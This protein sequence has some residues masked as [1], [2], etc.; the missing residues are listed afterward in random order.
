LDVSNDPLYP[1]GYGLSYSKFTYSNVKLSKTNLKGNET[2][3]A[4]VTVTNTGSY[5]GEE[6]VQLYISDPVASVSR[7][8][9]E[10]KGFKKIN[11]QVG[12]KKDV[13]FNI[14]TQQL[15][16]YNSQLKYDWEPGEF[17]IQIGTNSAETKIAKVQWM[18]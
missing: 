6:V 10:L 2:L 18:R 8:V 16:F 5:T 17:V 4:T 1:F 9:K 15:K 12:E 7:A 13:T 11:L 3:T 14:T